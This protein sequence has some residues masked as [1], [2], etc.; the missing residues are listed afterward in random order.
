MNGPRSLRSIPAR[1][2]RHP[3]WGSIAVVILLGLV[4][5]MARTAGA[6]TPCAPCALLIADNAML[7]KSTTPAHAQLL[8]QKNLGSSTGSDG[9]K[10]KGW[11][12][13]TNF[14]A[15]NP[16]ADGAEVCFSDGNPAGTFTGTTE[17]LTGQAFDG[18]K[19]WVS[20]GS[21][22]S[23]M[24]VDRSTAG[25][26]VKAKVVQTPTA[27]K[28]LVSIKNADKERRRLVRDDDPQCRPPGD[29]NGVLQDP[30]WVVGLWSHHVRGDRLR[31]QR[32]QHHRGLSEVGRLVATGPPS[33]LGGRAA[34]MRR[35]RP[36]PP[37]LKSRLGPRDQGSPPFTRTHPEPTMESILT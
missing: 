1:L 37:A 26:I 17:T 36:P 22:T 13:N 19:G 31:G 2:R 4:S 29:C 20:N 18:T 30:G 3:A 8:G 27:W 34:R 14:Q 7:D 6:A 28:V 16:E 10:V 9:L 12:P 35:R 25:K 5:S 32:E 24:Y 15:W 21:G 33:R 11:I 23:H